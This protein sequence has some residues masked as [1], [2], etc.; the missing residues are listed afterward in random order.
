MVLITKKLQGDQSD[1]LLLL[2]SAVKELVSL[3]K[4]V[5]GIKILS[6][7]WG[8]EYE[9]VTF[10]HVDVFWCMHSNMPLMEHVVST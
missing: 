10:V 7:Y 8:P 2:I 1:T 5:I 9:K 4:Y 3:N 6:S